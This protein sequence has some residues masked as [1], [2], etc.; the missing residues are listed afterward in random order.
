MSVLSVCPPALSC[1][2]ELSSSFIKQGVADYIKN[3][4]GEIEFYREEFKICDKKADEVLTYEENSD[5]L[6][7]ADKLL[8]AQLQRQN[9][10]NLPEEVFVVK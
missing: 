2:R 5:C 8:R 7:I 1:R 6:G 10:D 4:P 3:L 9:W